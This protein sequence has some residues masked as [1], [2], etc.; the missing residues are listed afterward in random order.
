VYRLASGPT[1]AVAASDHLLLQYVTPL[2][3]Q[4][5][6]VTITLSDHGPRTVDLP[7]DADSLDAADHPQIAAQLGV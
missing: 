4:Q 7:A 5:F 2:P 1:V 6:Q 3:D